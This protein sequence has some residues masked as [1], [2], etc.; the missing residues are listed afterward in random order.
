M[1]ARRETASTPVDGGGGRTSVAT[2]EST[3]SGWN[4]R[5]N[6]LRS[7][8]ARRPVTVSLA[9]LV[10]T[11]SI[12]AIC[13]RHIP[14]GGL[15]HVLGT[16]IDQLFA[17]S[18]WWTLITY[19]LAS[20]T[21]V[22]MLV[23]VLALLLLGWL[24]E[25]RMPR[26]VLIG[27][28]LAIPLLGAL[29]GMGVQTIAIGMGVGLPVLGSDG[30]VVDPLMIAVVIT[31]VGSAY[32]GPVDRRRARLLLLVVVIVSFLYLG[33]LTHLYRLTAA[34]IA[35]A[36]GVMLQPQSLDRHWRRS[37]AHE[38]RI[39][40]AVSMIV[41]GLGPIIGL[42]ATGP[43][44]LAA[45]LGAISRGRSHSCPAGQVTAQCLTGET[46]LIH[47]D[48]LQTLISILPWCVFF[49]I[50]W[51]IWKG[52]RLAL[53]AGALMC[54]AVAGLLGFYWIYAPTQLIEAGADHPIATRADG[55]E[56]F[57]QL[58]SMILLHLVVA[59]VLWSKRRVCPN[60]SSRR[61]VIRLCL[62]I[63]GTAVGLSVVYVVYVVSDITAFA[64]PP[65]ISQV[66]L[67]APDR[68]FP[69]ALLAIEPV[70]L[71]P[72]TPLAHLVTGAIAPVFAI[73]GLVALARTLAR[74]VPDVATHDRDEVLDLLKR[75][76]GTSMSYMGIWPGNDYW[77]DDVTGM[78]V[79]HRNVQGVAI[80]LAG[81]FGSS[82]ADPVQV[83]TRF[84]SVADEAGLVPCAYSVPGSWRERFEALG[85][86][87]LEVAEE[88][89]VDLADWSTKGRKWQDVRT[90]INRTARAGVE[91]EWS[92]WPD[93]TVRRA[94]QIRT[95][96]DVWVGD[97]PLPEMGFTLGGVD[98][99]A[100]PGTLLC[101]A[102]DADGSIEGVTSWLPC[103]RDGKLVGR[104]LDFMR[105]NPDGMNGVMEM[106][107][108]KAAERFREEGVEWMSLSG[109]PLASTAD[110]SDADALGRVL[111][112]LGEMLEPVY[113]FRT[114]LGF[115]KKFQPRFEPLI[116]A[117]PDATQLPNIGLAIGSAYLPGVSVGQAVQALRPR[118]HA[119]SRHT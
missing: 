9:V 46:S 12:L 75:G 107:I 70:E 68:L 111:D 2:E 90:S 73:V 14:G 99:L 112:R 102:L 15:V 19:P 58:G 72:A 36:V 17:D 42:L 119:D 62:V 33:H 32:L 8:M 21:I 40:L 24:F 93:L 64:T 11:L 79:A 61:D 69:P 5:L 76:G 108:A 1:S 98:E 45:P 96:N 109:A 88:S 60:K 6:P 65:T 49:V 47:L 23:G 83:L 118:R 54:L 22:Q 77:V 82:T 37:T 59:V 25:P 85:W 113:G 30:L 115:K 100:E 74:A 39:L 110:S 31:G 18:K 89:I 94:Q 16:G 106:M 95:L 117:Y 34:I 84:A 44:G 71:V 26:W 50:A 55:I 116:L 63:V 35:V 28:M 13:T 78:C 27:S 51:G 7:G 4:N 114:L 87:T 48:P 97:K 3:E 67:D 92:E 43:H 103:W 66:L 52:R 80:A 86:S 53:D 57:I 105:R 101:I 10:T 20:G 29:A 91:L 81:P 41:V 56:T 38:T 104:T